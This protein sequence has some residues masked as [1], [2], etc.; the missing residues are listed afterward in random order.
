MLISLS[1][2]A[3]LLILSAFFSGS[4][5]ALTAASR[6]LMHQ[7]ERNGDRRA[8][9]I[10]RL[11]EKKE[12]LIGAILLGNNLVNIMASALATGFLIGLFGEAGIAYAT[13]AMTLLILIF[14]EILPKTYAL[15][16]ANRVALASA[17]IVNALVFALAPA[18]GAVHLVVRGV[19]RLFGVAFD[20]TEALGS[21]AAEL[22]GAIDLH[23]GKGGAVKHERAMLRSIL[24]LADVEVGE[25]MVHRKTV[26]MIEADQPAA[27]VVDEA[28]AS[29][30]TR[31]PLWRGQPDNIVGV[32][33]SKALLTALRAAGGNLDGL[34]I[35]AL[36]AKPWFIPE[37]T[38]LLDQLQAFR[39]RHEHFALVVDEYGS[40]MGIVT[41]EDILEEIVGD[42]ADEHDVVVAGVRPQAD[43]SYVVEGS[44]TIRDLNRQFEW[45]LPDE[46]AA[47]AAGL[48]LHES[49]RIPE[50]GQAFMFHGFR[51]EILRRLRHQITS[52]RIT[53]PPRTASIGVPKE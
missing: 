32:L 27:A 17:P 50:V 48:I 6:P 15:R 49:R 14:S 5:T 13:I 28:L 11:Y 19:F 47:T 30:F 29:P 46:E 37:S 20:A 2:I 40:L 21:S 1:A 16:D 34:D 8:R 31:V 38:S 43:G 35:L 41:L 23:A 18:T 4:E 26:V 42:I 22:R 51:F 12:R 52:V 39:K 45:D 3:V 53:P 7:L 44:V 33:H 24:D 9:M 10:N 36:A 25:I